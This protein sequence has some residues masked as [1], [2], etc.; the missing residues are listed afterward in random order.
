MRKRWCGQ[1]LAHQ[2][3]TVKKK[4]DLMFQ[5]DHRQVSLRVSRASV[6]ANKI[7]NDLIKFRSTVYSSSLIILIGII[8]SLWKERLNS[9]SVSSVYIF[10]ESKKVV[11]T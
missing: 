9:I 8:Q 3:R 2:P 6:L 7:K 1:A 11:S 5:P 4:N 10:I